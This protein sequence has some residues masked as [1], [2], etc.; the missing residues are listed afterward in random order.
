MS[1][2]ALGHLLLC[3]LRS[4][5]VSRVPGVYTNIDVS[6]RMQEPVGERLSQNQL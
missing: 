4:Q 6:R 2:K 1:A 5:G 3:L